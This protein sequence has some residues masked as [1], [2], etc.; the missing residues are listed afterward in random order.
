MSRIAR[1]VITGYPYHITQRG[2]YQQETFADKRDYIRYLT[3]LEEYK[4]KY[5]LS[6]LAYCLM[7]NHVHFIAIPEKGDSLAKTFN[8]CHM[9][10]SQYFNRKRKVVGHL[11]Q[12]RFYSCA[13]DE[14]HLY[15][16]IRYVET[17]PV[18]AKLVKNPE[19]WNWSSARFHINNQ[20]GTLSLYGVDKLINID[21]WKEYLFQ[22]DD[23]RMILKIRSD[24]LTGRPS[25][26][27]I[28]IQKFENLLKRQLVSAPI[29]RPKN[30]RC[31]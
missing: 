10:Y 17:N 18:R 19:D 16:A 20:Q 30:S 27:I 11:W 13:L 25:G 29:G 12:G 28:F 6:L 9:R 2:N 5:N 3:W 1:V 8:T 26:D 15:A 21:N 7:P 23:E 4:N 24:T 22:N 14:K 31:P